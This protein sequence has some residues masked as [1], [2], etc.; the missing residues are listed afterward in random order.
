MT[1]LQNENLNIPLY[2]SGFLGFHSW[3]SKWGMTLF[4]KSFCLTRH[5][6]ADM[7]QQL[8]SSPCFTDITP[9]STNIL[10]LLEISFLKNLTRSVA[11]YLQNKSKK[12]T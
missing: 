1:N 9:L 11:A 3:L 10:G 12:L 5:T 7:N 8:P 6:K 2:S 4:S